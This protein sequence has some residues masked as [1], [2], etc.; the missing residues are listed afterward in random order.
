MTANGSSRTTKAFIAALVAAHLERRRTAAAQVYPTRPV[1]IVVPF[2]GGGAKRI[3]AR[4]LA[5]HMGQALGS[6]S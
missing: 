1:T 2:A 3:L 5:Q 6:N 4:L